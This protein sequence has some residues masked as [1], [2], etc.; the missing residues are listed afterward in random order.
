MLE[1]KSLKAQF[2]MSFILVIIFSIIPTI[3]TYFIGYNIYIAVEYKNIYP[4][5][6]YERKASDIGDYLKEKGIETLDIREK[7]ALDKLI[8]AEGIKYQVINENAKVIYGTDREK[9]IAD[10]AD[11]YKKVNTRIGLKGRYVNIIPIL[12]TKGKMAGVVSLSYMLKPY[13]VNSADKIWM[14]PLSIIIIFSPFIYIIFFTII[15]SS[16]FQHSIGKPLNMLIQAAKEVK[17]KNLDF[18]VDYTADNEIGKLCEAFNE[19]K[20]ELKISLI[21]QWKI[22]QERHEM[23]ETLAHD[24]KTPLS[25]I[26][27][28][29]ESLLDGNYRDN[30]KSIRYLNVIRENT[31]KGSNLIK[32]MLYAAEIENTNMEINSSSVDIEAFMKIK[33]ESYE[34]I[35]KDKKIKIKVNIDY[36][37]NYKISCSIDILKLERILDNIVLNSIYYTPEEGKI[38]IN[39]YVED[40]NMKFTVQD[41]GKGFSSKDLSNIFYKFYRGDKA[42]SSK[43]GNAGLGL[44]IAKKLVEIYGGSIKAFNSESG[45][46][47]VEFILKMI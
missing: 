16:K 24:L 22:E 38:N 6:Y 32:E 18:S 34:M 43:N 21:S 26:K 1:K 42:R 20:S 11:L 4:A 30:E 15:F 13:Y 47:C 7:Q 17:R 2:V 46:A 14:I 36:K 33:E 3:I 28:Y 23:V 45:G 9:I 19:M 31:D 10:S 25:I 8:P 44:Y 39:V 27:G 40:K 12:D 41:T 35:C 37:N 29:T 5:N